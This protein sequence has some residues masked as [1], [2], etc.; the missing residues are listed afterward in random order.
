[1]KLYEF[2]VN[3][4]VIVGGGALFAVPNGLVGFP[5]SKVD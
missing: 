5:N 4:I 1:M 2:I 3:T